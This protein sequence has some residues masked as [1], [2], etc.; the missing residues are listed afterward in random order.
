[1]D[2]C[3]Y[4]GINTLRRKP[5]RKQTIEKHHTELKKL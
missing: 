1:M 5:E 4:H 3:I 2:P